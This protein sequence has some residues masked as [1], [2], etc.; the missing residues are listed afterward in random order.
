MF[1]C[2]LCVTKNKIP[3]KRTT[4]NII[5][6]RISN[7]KLKIIPLRYYVYKGTRRPV[8]Y[9]SLTIKTNYYNKN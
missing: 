6:T 7:D 9:F 3:V 1:F 5:K 4:T 2:N 8:T